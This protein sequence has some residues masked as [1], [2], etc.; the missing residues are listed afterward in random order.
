MRITATGMLPAHRASRP[1]ER[2]NGSGRLPSPADPPT[3][4]ERT[5]KFRMN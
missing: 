5:P 4:W 3:I 1:N 2:R